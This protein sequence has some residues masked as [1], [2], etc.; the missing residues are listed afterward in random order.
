M[1]NKV[2][3][4]QEPYKGEALKTKQTLIAGVNGQFYLD[5]VYT[6]PNGIKWLENSRGYIHAWE[7][8]RL[9]GTLDKPTIMYQIVHYRLTKENTLREIGNTWYNS[10][11][12]AQ[13]AFA[14]I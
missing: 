9:R 12:E 7:I 4:V 14:E 3:M 8:G 11:E 13:Q 2:R 1:S 10:L 6:L 5:T